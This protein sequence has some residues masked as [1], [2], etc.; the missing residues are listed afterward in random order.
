MFEHM[1]ASMKGNVNYNK[2]Y[3]E[4]SKD[5]YQTEIDKE[6]S[7]AIN[8]YNVDIEKTNG[9]DEYVGIQVRIDRPFTVTGGTKVSDDY[10]KLIFQNNDLKLQTG[11]KVKFDDNCWLL[12]DIS[13]LSVNSIASIARRC[14]NVI[15]YKEGEEYKVEPCVIDY[16]SSS[17]QL[18]VKQEI[19][20]PSKTIKMYTQ[21]NSITRKIKINNRFIFGSQVFKVI[22][23]EDYNQISTYDTKIGINVYNLELDEIGASD[24]FETGIAAHGLNSRVTTK[25]KTVKKEEINIE[26]ES[27][28][29]TSETLSIL[30]EIFTIKEGGYVDYQIFA[31]ERDVT[32]MV[33]WTSEGVDVRRYKINRIDNFIRISCLNKDLNNNLV[34]DIVYNNIHKKINIKLR[35]LF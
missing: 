32:N 9:A 21:N 24:N 18:E 26:K 1:N 19:I 6:F 2:T 16:S 17:N 25:K 3:S 30:P 28:E 35:G 10:K 23:K 11:R 34:V 22:S 8:L 27:V 4:I 5:L 14:N 7:Y 12:T 20:L 31:N 15:H 13:T 29:A 33:N